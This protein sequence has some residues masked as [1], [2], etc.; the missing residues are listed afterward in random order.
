MTIDKKSFNSN[1]NIL[2]STLHGHVSCYTC[3]KINIKHS[4]FNFFLLVVQ[5][6]IIVTYTLNLIHLNIIILE[7]QKTFHVLLIN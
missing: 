1:N 2:L 7:L 3:I 6:I 5:I 4:Q